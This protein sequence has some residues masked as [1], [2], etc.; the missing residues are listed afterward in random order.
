MEEKVRMR[1]AGND[2][3]R[4]NEWK[5]WMNSRNRHHFQLWISNPAISLQPRPGMFKAGASAQV[6]TDEHNIEEQI[7]KERVG[8]RFLKPWLETVCSP[9]SASED[10]ICSPSSPVAGE[11][12]TRNKSN[13]SDRVR[14][15]ILGPD[16]WWHD[17][18]PTP[19]GSV[20]G[21]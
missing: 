7:R 4:K 11:H 16:F 18:R 8:G 13:K 20:R 19:P 6:I 10:W 3:Q 21:C 17:G 12:R 1:E 14:W 2:T 5:S 9:T 15:Q